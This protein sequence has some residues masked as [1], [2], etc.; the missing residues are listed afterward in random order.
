MQSATKPLI[1]VV[2]MLSMV[3][4]WTT[5]IRVEYIDPMHPSYTAIAPENTI[6][7]LTINTWAL[8]FNGTKR[9]R[10]KHMCQ[11]INN[12]SPDIVL[13]QEVWEQT[14]YKQ[15]IK[16]CD[17]P[18]YTEYGWY[19][20]VGK[21][22]GMV[23][24]SKHRIGKIEKIEYPWQLTFPNPLKAAMKAEI[25]ISGRQ[26]IYVFN[27]HLTANLVTSL[28]SAYNRFGKL[29]FESDYEEGTRLEQLMVLT[30]SIGEAVKENVPVIS[31]G[32]LNTGPRYPLWYGWMG[33]M[34]KSYGWLY[35][36]L[37][38]TWGLGSTYINKYAGQDQG[39]LD[40]IMG[41]GLARIVTTKVVLNEEVEMCFNK[42][43]KLSNYSD[44]YGLMSVISL[45]KV[46]K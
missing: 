43:C 28:G 21:Y 14:D 11:A 42:H 5:C 31:G 41:W 40:H 37:T 46:G 23:I 36:R 17:Y 2:M 20:W 35:D 44:H 26:K 12:L 34:H 22:C 7:L 45:P 8:P 30:R 39:Q 25:F 6:T 9:E 15:I 18:Y 4:T 33:W 19:P 38:Y 13:M 3:T 16:L 29:M 27:T 10:L 1:K 32:D 24:L